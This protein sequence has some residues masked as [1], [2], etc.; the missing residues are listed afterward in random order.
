MAARAAWSGAISF[1]GFPINV[2]LYPRVKSRSSESFKTLAPTN[3]QPVK[4]QLVDTDGTVVERA[5]CIKGV[6]V[7]KDTFSPLTPEAV[8]SINSAERSVMLEP[9]RFC[10]LDTLPISLTQTAYAVVPDEK[11]PGSD[12]PAGILWNGL[13]ETGLALLTQIVPRAGSRDSIL[14][15]WADEHG[16]HAS[17]L[18]Y[19]S[20]LNDA[21]SWEPIEDEAAAQTFEAFV[22]Q[23]YADISGDFEH[24]AF[25]SVYKEHRAEIV[26]A[27]LKGEKIEVP[28]IAQAQAAT[29][30]LM[31]AM[32]ASIADTKGQAPK[33]KKA[34]KKPAKK[35]AKE[36]AE[37]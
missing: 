17:A 7:G 28:E 37:A 26:Q 16:L 22:E 11:V 3:Q 33:A 25:T 19:A 20:E 35:Q 21:P 18:P 9:E 24:E 12:Q 15:L 34:A 10:P 1:G 6:P 27:A 4:Q 31:A 30:D 36:P 13:R 2:R 14:A 8:E 29:P 32:Q 5:D 23:K